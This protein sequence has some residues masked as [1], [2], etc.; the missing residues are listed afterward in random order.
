MLKHMALGFNRK[1]IASALKFEDPESLVV[2]WRQITE[3]FGT[4]SEFKIALLAKQAGIV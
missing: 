4:K 3:R 2:Y 1:Q